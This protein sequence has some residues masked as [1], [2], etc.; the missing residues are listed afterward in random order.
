MSSFANLDSIYFVQGDA[1]NDVGMLEG[2]A[3]GVAV[4]NAGS[5]AKDASDIVLP[6]T[7]SEGGVG[8]ALKEILGVEY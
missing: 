5:A 7:A 1:E 2:S 3:V 8:L 4:G 6:L